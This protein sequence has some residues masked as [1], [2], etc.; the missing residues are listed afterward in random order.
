MGTCCCCAS[1]LLH[2]P[3]EQ[4]G[5]VTFYGTELALLPLLRYN[6]LTPIPHFVNLLTHV[7]LSR[8]GCSVPQAGGRLRPCVNRQGQ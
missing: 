1:L 6:L 7:A 4:R 8:I 2:S 3:P 5:L